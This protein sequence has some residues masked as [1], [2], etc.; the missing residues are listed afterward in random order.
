MIQ[1]LSR[2]ARQSVSNNTK[3]YTKVFPDTQKGAWISSCTTEAKKYLSTT[4]EQVLPSGLRNHHTPMTGIST[5]TLGQDVFLT[6]LKKDTE[7]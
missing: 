5:A 3:C 2:L 1:R 4:R 6:H 7:R